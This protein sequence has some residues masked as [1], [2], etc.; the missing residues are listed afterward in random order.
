MAAEKKQTK[1]HVDPRWVKTATFAEDPGYDKKY[2]LSPVEEAIAKSITTRRTVKVLGDPGTGKSATAEAATPM[3]GKS[4][5]FEDLKFVK[6]NALNKAPD[7]LVFVAPDMIQGTLIDMIE[8][9]LVPG[10]PFILCVDDSLKAPKI[11]QNQLMQLAQE[12]RLGSFDLRDEGCVGVVFLDNIGSEDGFDIED[13]PQADRY[14]TMHADFQVMGHGNK[15]Y[16]ARKYANTDLKE[17]FKYIE[18]LGGS[19]RKTLSWRGIDHMIDVTL[20]G[21]PGEWAIPKTDGRLALKRTK[22]GKDLTEEVVSGFAKALG[23]R[24]VKESDLDQPAVRLVEA[25]LK[26]NWTV[27][28]EGPPGIGKTEMV[29]SAIQAAGLKMVSF[30]MPL[31]DWDTQVCPIPDERGLIMMLNER[32]KDETPKVIFIDEHNR[33]KDGLAMSRA[34]EVTHDRTLGGVPIPNVRAVI[35]A[36]NPEEWLGHKLDTQPSSMAQA[37]RFVASYIVNPNDPLAGINPYPWLIEELPKK[38]AEEDPQWYGDQVDWLKGVAE[39]V[40]EWHKSDIDD[41]GR[42]WVSPRT[43][44]RF[45]RAHA[46]EKL[47][48]TK[49]PGYKENP[50]YLEH[51]LVWLASIAEADE[52][53]GIGVHGAAPVS[54]T[55]LAVRLSGQEVI[56]LKEL[57]LNID[58]WEERA[59]VAYEDGQEEGAS[60]EDLERLLM[61]FH[62]AEVSQLEEHK[63]TV[64]R[65]FRYLRRSMLSTLVCSKDP[66]AQNF[67]TQMILGLE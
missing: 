50:H 48:M 44:E 26:H 33:P 37:D 52:D 46:S 49:L 2:G 59:K 9:S 13:I 42:A 55:N 1:K 65:L 3:V 56:G 61:I 8:Q 24:R 10:T 53:T 7:D 57:S 38:M 40:V 23:V 64:Q 6:L 30:S 41:E 31:T 18:T 60:S 11:V 5:G 4:L 51:C 43:L 28:V 15:L 16:L 63:E 45:I 36:E 54:L 67:W 20:E 47:V 34:M 39:Q 21:L 19:I 66:N 58:M 62:N 25:A 27:R 14:I 29:K 35:A 22:D 12:W 17:L 32:L